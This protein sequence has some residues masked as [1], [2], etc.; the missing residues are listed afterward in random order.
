MWAT[1]QLRSGERNVL[2]EAML[3]AAQGAG[4]QQLMAQV[5]ACVHA[6]VRVRAQGLMA[7]HVSGMCCRAGPGLGMIKCGSVTAHGAAR[8]ASCKVF[9]LALC[10]MEVRCIMQ[11]TNV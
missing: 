8:S 1:Q 6:C 2:S 3:A 4:G 11:A 7:S 10:S 5:C 9:R